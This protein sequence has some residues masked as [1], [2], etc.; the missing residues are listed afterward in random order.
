MKSFLLAP[1]RYYSMSMK[2][3]DTIEYVNLDGDAIYGII[4]KGVH[5]HSFDT[6]NNLVRDA[7]KVAWMD[8][9]AVTTEMARDILD[10]EY[11]GLVLL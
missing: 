8:D 11:T 6:S 4:C 10:P 3:G 1:G 2:V 7:V 5:R 9:G